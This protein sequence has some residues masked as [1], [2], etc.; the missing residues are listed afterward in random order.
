M[1]R[2]VDDTKCDPPPPSSSIDINVS[3]AKWHTR[4]DPLDIASAAINAAMKASGSLI[5]G[6]CEVSLLFC[7][8]AVMAGINNEWRGLD[9]PTNVLSFP[10]AEFPGQTFPRPLGDIIIALEISQKEAADAGLSFESHVTHLIVHGFLH[11]LG[12]DHE[13][14]NDAHEMETMEADILAG[15]G[16]ANPYLESH[17]GKQGG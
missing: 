3:E 9:K 2:M 1:A 14:D 6:D 10:A 15:M 4:L 7:N 13:T 17:P 5:N 12:Y 11:L 8:D 16:I